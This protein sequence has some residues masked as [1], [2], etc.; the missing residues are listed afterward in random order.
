MRRLD[1]ARLRL[2][3]CL[4][5]LSETFQTTT[6]KRLAVNCEATFAY[7]GRLNIRLS[8]PSALS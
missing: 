5:G 3:N 8:D 7:R 4:A 6:G 1:P 2:P